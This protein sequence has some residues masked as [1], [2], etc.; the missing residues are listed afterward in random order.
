MST[1]VVTANTQGS[2]L[3]S[4]TPVSSVFGGDMA[5]QDTPRSVTAVSAQLLSDANISDLSDF[6]KVAPSAYTTDQFG[7][8]SVPNIRGQEAEVFINGMQRTT[9]ADGPPT[10]FNA[11]DTANVVAGPASSVYGPTANTGGY[12]DLNTKQPY[13]DKFH[14]DTEFTYGQ[15][16]EKKWT[17]D[18]GGPITPELAY[19]VSYFG[20]YSGSY[21]NNVLTQENDIFAAL[22]WIP[23]KDFTV[24]ING[25]FYDGRFNEVTGWN[26]PTQGLIDGHQYSSGFYAPFTGTVAGG[27]GVVA[28]GTATPRG[29]GTFGGLVYSPGTQYISGPT[30]LVGPNDSDY[31]KD[32]NFE[33]KETY[34]VNDNLTLVN[35]TYWEYFELRNYEVAQLYVND[36]QFQHRAKPVRDSLQFRY[37]HQQWIERQAVRSEGR[38]GHE[39][40]VFD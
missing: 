19:R 31:S 40:D 39:A 36:A 25:D 37:S 3:P 27:S 14:S 32:A 2:V 26:R 34:N 13:F 1:I 28:P 21:Y 11:V 16:D 23:N 9:R 15:W 5:V 10:N 29:Y 24:D 17:E 4:D 33:V 38:E 30:N 35:H 12:I 22:K 6:V 18:F 8:A 20:D 7:V